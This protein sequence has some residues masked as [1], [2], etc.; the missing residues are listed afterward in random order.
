DYSSLLREASRT[1]TVT[2][3]CAGNAVGG[4][5]V[6][7]A[8]W[9]G[10]PLERLL[11]R[12]GLSSR[13]KHVRL[14]GADRGVEDPGR[15]PVFYMRSL[16]AEKALHPDTLLAY[17]MNGGPLPVEHGFPLRAVVPGWYAMDSVKWLVHIRALDHEDR[18]IFMTERY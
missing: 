2:L 6:G 10:V 17:Q 12:A 15:A 9:T 13:V 16:P 14:V 3:E 1:L 5:A 7:T 11:R 18:S 8:R 4:G